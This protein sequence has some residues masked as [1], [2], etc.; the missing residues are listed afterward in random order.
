MSSASDMGTHRRLSD[1]IGGGSGFDTR[2]FCKSSRSVAAGSSESG[3]RMISKVARRENEKDGLVMIGL[4]SVLV[5]ERDSRGRETGLMGPSNDVYI[6]VSISLVVQSTSVAL[7]T[8]TYSHNKCDEHRDKESVV[9]GCSDR[10]CWVPGP[11]K[12]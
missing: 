10:K 6:A 12:P 3:V 7:V 9:I 8:P 5:S 1:V 11:W 2:Q 4:R